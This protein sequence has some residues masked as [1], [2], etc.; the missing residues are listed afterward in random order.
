MPIIKTHATYEDLIALPDN[1]IAEIVDGNLHGSPR[2]GL[3]HAL[4]TSVLGWTLGRPL[5]RP[6]GSP[7]GWWILGRPEVHLGDDV[8]VPDLAGWRHDHLPRVPDVPWMSL[9]PDWLCEVVS[10]ETERLDRVDKPR[11][12]DA[13]T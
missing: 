7:G 8:L 6:D 9:A 12:Y 11:A 13:R 3:R 5:E 4:A 2:P 10:P 1:L